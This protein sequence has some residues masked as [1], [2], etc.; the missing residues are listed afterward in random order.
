MSLTRLLIPT[1]MQMLKAL[2]GWLQ[3]AEAQMPK[4]DA[5]ALLAARLAP[6]MFPLSTQIRFVCVQA[7][8]PVYRLRGEAFPTSIHQLVDEGRDAIDKPGSLSDAHARID[9]TLNLLDG[10]AT[11]ALDV[12][13]RAPIVHE[14]PSGMVFDLTAEQYARDWTL[15]QF[16]FHLMT[17]YAILRSERVEL[18]KVDY[19]PHMLGFLRPETISEA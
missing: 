10:L 6:D 3:K 18:G 2:S 7:Q 9:E 11:D 1:Y 19:I 8:E 4:E 14:L 16:Y 17:A 15:A 12:D 13:P 5:E